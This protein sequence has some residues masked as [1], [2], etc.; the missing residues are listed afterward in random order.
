MATLTR[1]DGKT[2][3]NILNSKEVEALIAK[4]EAQE[5]ENEAAKKEKQQQQ[6]AQ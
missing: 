4:F 2:V 1:V 6:Q 3:I 5:A